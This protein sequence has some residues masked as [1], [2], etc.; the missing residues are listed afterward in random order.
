MMARGVEDAVEKREVGQ[1]CGES[2]G[3]CARVYV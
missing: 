1:G 2:L 3:V